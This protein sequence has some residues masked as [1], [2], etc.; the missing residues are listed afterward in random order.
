MA[1]A[2]WEGQVMLGTN[3]S[4]IENKDTYSWILSTTLDVLVADACSA[5]AAF[6]PRLTTLT[7][8]QNAPK[9]QLFML[10]YIGYIIS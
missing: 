5:E 4:V 6:H 10:A 2:L 1:K 8:L 9:Q 7:T 3:G